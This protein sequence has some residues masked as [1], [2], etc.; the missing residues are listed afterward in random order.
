VREAAAW[1]G[2]EA[3]IRTPEGPGVV[4]ACAAGE[5]LDW[6]DAVELGTV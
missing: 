2:V 1:S 6:P 4:V 3:A 5:K